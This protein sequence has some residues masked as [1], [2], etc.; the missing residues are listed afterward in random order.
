MLSNNN[1]NYPTITETQSC[2]ILTSLTKKIFCFIFLKGYNLH[3]PKLTTCFLFCSSTPYSPERTE[4]SVYS[5]PVSNNSIYTEKRVAFSPD[6]SKLLF[7]KLL[8]FEIYNL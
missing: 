4:A 2:Q 3:V 7:N 8:T 6:N 5:N 1:K